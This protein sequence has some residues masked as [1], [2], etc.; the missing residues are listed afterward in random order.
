M[1]GLVGTASS[2]G[3]KSRSD[4]VQFMK[5]GLDIDSWR[6]WESTGVALTPENLKDAP[7]IY[8][9]ALN[10]RDFIQ[11]KQVDKLFNDLE[12]FPVAI[13][14]N[15]AATTG[16]GNIVDHNAHPFQY[17][18]ITL[19]HNGHIR[20]THSL[21]GAQEGAQCLVDSSHVAFSMN[22]NGEMETLEQVDGGFV[23]VWWNQA[24][25]LL[26]VARNTERPFHFAY[27][28]RENTLYWASEHT[29][30]LHLM[31]DIAID[32]DLGILYPKPW[33]WYQ[34]DLKDLRSYKKIPFVKRQGWQKTTQGTH[35]N[36][37]SM[38]GRHRGD[39]TAMNGAY[40]G[41]TDEEMEAWER[42]EFETPS[43]R[44][45]KSITDT[46][47]K[48]EDAAEIDEIRQALANQRLKDVKIAGIP[49][50]P[51]RIKRA[52][53]ELRKLGID[54]NAMRNCEPLSWCKYKNQDNLGSVLARTKKDN[55]LVEV[56]Q[57]RHEQFQLYSKHNN[58]LVDCIN[59]RNGPNN[60]FRVIGTVSPRM[61]KYI[62]DHLERSKREEAR[63]EGGSIERNLD[64]PDGLKISLDRFVELSDKGCANCQSDIDPK[65]HGAITWVGR[66]SQPICPTCSSDPGIMELLGVPEFYRRREAGAIH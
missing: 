13:G 34:Y 5:M 2:E 45:E 12:K 36:V 61:T 33:N 65:H 48:A 3:M 52:K 20:N 46:S 40:A 27:A 59:V 50:S 38:R 57:V 44:I 1:C 64:G 63:G 7:I 43:E 49:T 32:E 8:K 41:W 29:M 39:T 18:N 54:Y 19:V 14:H 24:T 9:R 58:L 37:T 10:G 62:T 30:L 28:E 51:K 31:K 25:Q 17:G 56:L 22:A 42:G 55:L 35:S 15:R 66:P 16:R 26:N 6:G 21:K 53:E 60:D 4:R 47:K 23:F 11:L